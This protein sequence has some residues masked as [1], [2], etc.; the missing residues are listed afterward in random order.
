MTRGALLI[1]FIIYFTTSSA[2]QNAILKFLSD[3]SMAHASVSL[4]IIDAANSE[5]IAENNPDKSLQPASVMKLITTAASIDLLGRAYT[6]KT[7]LAYS[8][9]IKK[10]S[11]KLN[12]NIIIIGGG[13]PALGSENFPDQYGNFVKKWVEVI[14]ELG[15]KRIR[16]RVVTDDS[17][18]DYLPV[19]ANWNWED[20]GN[21]YGAG[22]YG[23]SIFDNTLKIHF[24][25]GAEGSIPVL[26][27]I[28]PPGSGIE[29]R[30]FLRSHGSADEGYV[31]SAPYSSGGWIAGSIPADMVDFVLKASIPDPPLFAA[32]LL[33]KELKEA[34]IKISYSASTARLIPGLQHDKISVIDEI[35]SP[36]L[37]SI[38]EVLNHK[39]I[40]LYAEDLVKELGRSL[41]GEGSA[42]AGKKVIM[43]YLDSCGIGTEGMFIEDG[44]GLSTQDAINS[45]Q[46]VKLLLH[47]KK[48]SSSFGDYL[49]SLPDPGKE[50][51]LKKYFRDEAFDS[52]LKAKSG[53]MTWVRSF[54][55][56]FTT[57]TGKE[58]IFSIIVNNYTGPAI[59]VI[60]G[61]EEI[62]KE[63]ILNL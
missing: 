47:M 4:Y 33:E 48:N 15:I 11:G 62:I 31:F 6:F 29:F 43:Q 63:C 51:T 25:T 22:V 28:Q 57:M 37:S 9:K 16:G 60:S 38:I 61:M 19:P 49:N 14:S 50:G 2:Q 42:S 54:A 7:T 20:I 36:P 35:T 1:P 26:T 12:G 52:R 34:G 45:R 10:G 40:N 58:M 32:K 8:G 39:S 59:K 23:L 18:Y 46:L 27:T 41:K 30:N 53:S 13:D 56:Y 24:K 3:S 17:Y 44:S 55:G 5:I 21:Y